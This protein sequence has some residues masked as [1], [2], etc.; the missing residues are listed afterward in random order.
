MADAVN[1][2]LPSTVTVTIANGANLSGAF[3]MSGMAG[4]VVHMPAAWTS[5]SLG[6]KVASDESGTYQVLRDDDGNLIQVDSPAASNSYVLPAATFP[7][8]WAKLWS[9]DGSGNDAAQGAARS[10]VI[11][12]K[13]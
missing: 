11:D 9:Q 2:R 6:L 5:A 8:R 12:L 13:P 3:D 10:L 7:V 1:T 4:A